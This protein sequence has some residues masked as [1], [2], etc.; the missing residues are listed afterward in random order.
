MKSKKKKMLEWIFLVGVLM[1]YVVGGVAYNMFNQREVCECERTIEPTDDGRFYMI[2]NNNYSSEVFQFDSSGTILKTYIE[3][4]RWPLSLRQ[5]SFEGVMN[6]DGL[7]LYFL[8]TH[9]D[10]ETGCIEQYEIVRLEDNGLQLVARDVYSPGPGKDLPQACAIRVED[11]KVYLTSLWSDL[12]TVQLEEFD[13]LDSGELFPRSTRKYVIP[14]EETVSRAIYL[15]GQVVMVSNTGKIYLT[16][17]SS[18]SLISPKESGAQNVIGFIAENDSEIVF[19]ESETDL[20]YRYRLLTGETTQSSVK[21][22]IGADNLRAY[23]ILYASLDNERNFAAIATLSTYDNVQIYSWNSGGAPLIVPAFRVPFRVAVSMSAGFIWFSCAITLFAVIMYKVL[24]RVMNR[25]RKIVF[26]FMKIVSVFVGS[27]LILLGVNEYQELL[28]VHYSTREKMAFEL[29]GQIL[30]E[31]SGDMVKELGESRSSYSE[32]YNTVLEDFEILN[33]QASVTKNWDG[34]CYYNQVLVLS[35]EGDLLIGPSSYNDFLTPVENVYS[36]ADCDLFYGALKANETKTGRVNNDYGE[37]IMCSM[38]IKDKSS[39][40]VGVLV[41]LVDADVRYKVAVDIFEYCAVAGG[42]LVLLVFLIYLFFKKVLIPLT[43][44]EES[45]KEIARGNYGVRLLGDLNDEFSSINSTFNKMCEEISSSVYNLRQIK[46]NYNKFVSEVV[47]KMFRETNVNNINVGD[48]IESDSVYVLQS[49]GD[50]Y[51]KELT[52]PFVRMSGG[53]AVDFLNRLFRVVNTCA[54]RNGGAV[55]ANTLGVGLLRVLF[56]HDKAKEAIDY[57]LDVSGAI[58]ASFDE[59]TS[60]DFVT[61]IHKD[62]TVFGI[63]GDENNAFP[64]LNS[65]DI[66]RLVRIVPR[67]RKIGVRTVVTRSLVDEAKKRHGVRYIGFVGTPGLERRFEFFEV[68]DGCDSSE[69]S[70]KLSTKATFEN[71]IKMFYSGEFYEARS[72]F[73]KVIQECA[74]D[75]VAR[76]YLLMC[77]KYYTNPDAAVSYE[78]LN[79]EIY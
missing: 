56:D 39:N 67:L 6:S 5:T 68:L 12:K 64:V 15:R 46:E 17:D 76:W 75:E 63:I 26:K 37:W 41:T 7:H 71:G 30:G 69:K 55:L 18:D 44:L 77:D 54:A 16:S 1:A 11:E 33:M 45:F 19:S 66:E 43:A 31:I 36:R 34:I 49:V 65:R 28:T 38:P 24:I 74:G 42:A 2:K 60:L 9:R 10:V 27:I 13:A 59:I 32:S 61:L 47:F 72:E 25:K 70:Q 35:T 48:S 78:L 62:R 79:D 52:R 4:N 53:G 23:D 21:Q 50:L 29:G 57:S 3:R 51:D 14:G 58:M 8:R 40:V 20:I 73:S 22:F